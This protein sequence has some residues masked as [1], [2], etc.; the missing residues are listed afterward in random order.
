VRVRGSV[1]GKVYDFAG[2]GA[3][4]TVAA[5]DV[6]DLLRTGLFARR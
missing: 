4:Q 6:P 1:S 3:T 5:A 2:G